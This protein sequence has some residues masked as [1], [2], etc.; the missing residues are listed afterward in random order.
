MEFFQLFIIVFLLVALCFIGLAIKVLVSKRGR[1]PNIH[2]GGNKALQE[3]GITCFTSY[4][5]MEQEQAKRDLKFKKLSLADD[6]L[7]VSC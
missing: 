2:I 7:H 5:K 4:D 6:E 1:F 3:R